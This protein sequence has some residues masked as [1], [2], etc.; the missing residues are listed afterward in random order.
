MSIRSFA[1]GLPTSAVGGLHGLHRTVR[2]SLCGA[3]ADWYLYAPVFLIWGLAFARLFIDPTPHVPLL[4][5]W[6]FSL[7][8]TVAVMQ[9]G[10]EQP[11]KRGDFVVYAFA[12]EAQHMYPGLQAQP[13]FKR[14]RGIPGDRVTVMD[15]QVLVN[16][17]SAGFAKPYT[18]DGHP[19]E[20]I[21][22][23]MIPPGYYYVQ[24][25]DPN[26][27]DSRYRAS[28]LVSAGQVIGKVI[29]LF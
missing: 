2:N 6:S 18:F 16:G 20:P 27:F 13:F 17:T 25:T 5:N 28:G 7:P 22:E 8:Y 3:R 1:L 15:R 10:S 21:A 12:G 14:I 26:S 24:G 19:L 9:P 11:L 23:T 29:P 4:F